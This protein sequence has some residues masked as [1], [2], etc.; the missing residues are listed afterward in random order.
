MT[1]VEDMDD[2]KLVGLY[3]SS[4]RTKEVIAVMMCRG[5][6]RADPTDPNPRFIRLSDTGSAIY[7][8]FH[9]KLRWDMPIEH[10]P[11]PKARKRTAKEQ[12]EIDHQGVLYLRKLRDDRDKWKAECRKARKDL[13]QA[14]K[15]KQQWCKM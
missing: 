3:C 11:S 14:N 10:W 1:N 6:L 9:Q 7:Q 15:D 4:S 12:R 8:E 2:N 13:R 5:L